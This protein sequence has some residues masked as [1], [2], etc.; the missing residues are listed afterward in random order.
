[1]NKRLKQKLRKLEKF[2][3]YWMKGLGPKEIIDVMKISH[4][5]YYK[6]KNELLKKGELK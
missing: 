1:L 2:K 5:Y 6:I 3:K 4:T